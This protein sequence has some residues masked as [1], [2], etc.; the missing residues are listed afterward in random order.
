[1]RVLKIT[2]NNPKNDCCHFV[3]VFSAVYL[4]PLSCNMDVRFE[5]KSDKE[6]TISNSV[7]FRSLMVRT[8]LEAY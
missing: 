5:G 3:S 7:S 6:V 1:M 4:A 2:K 8:K